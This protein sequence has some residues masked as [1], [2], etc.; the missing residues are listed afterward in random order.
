[1]LL[2]HPNVKHWKFQTVTPAGGLVYHHML[3]PVIIT[4]YANHYRL[5]RDFD[6][7]QIPQNATVRLEYWIGEIPR[8]SRTYR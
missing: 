7:E 5:F 4:V 8:K 2:K 1:M 3:R 6:G